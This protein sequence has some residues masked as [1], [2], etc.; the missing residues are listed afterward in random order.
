MPHIYPRT[1]KHFEA[2]IARFRGFDGGGDGDGGNIS[3][4]GNGK[5]NAIIGTSDEEYPR[6]LLFIG[7]TGW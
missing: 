7:Q 1:A 2:A 6:V 4:K 5:G 3:G